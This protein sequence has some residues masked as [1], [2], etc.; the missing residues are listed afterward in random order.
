MVREATIKAADLYPQSG[1]SARSIAMLERLVRDYPTPV[2]DAIEVRQRLLDMAVKIGNLERQRYWQREI[3]KAD[4]NAG[5]GRTDR[6]KYLAAQA[7]LA[8]TEPTRDAFR[9]I[10]LVA[11]L[12]QSLVAKKK[13]HGSGGPGVQG[14]GC[15]PGCGDHHRGHLSRRP[16]CIALL[17]HDLIAS[18]RP[19]KLSEEEL[20]QYNS[21]LEEQA[22]PF[23]EQAISIHEIN[24]KRTGDGVYDESVRKSFD[25]A[26][27][28]QAGALR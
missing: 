17:A 15:L 8:L 21:L 3:V 19:K 12:K 2:A 16:S 27:E 25:C 24:A 9:D 28:A 23:E 11:P 4:A 20:E 1:D 18:E 13:A 26:G 5:A 10:K 22:Y 7:Q 6:T 14:G